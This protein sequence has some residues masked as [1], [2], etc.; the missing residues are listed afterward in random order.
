MNNISIVAPKNQSS[1]GVEK[2]PE[3]KPFPSHEGR[4]QAAASSDV[5]RL[6]QRGSSPVQ[7]ASAQGQSAV[8]ARE[9]SKE[10]SRP[11]TVSTLRVAPSA[12]D[13]ESP[14]SPGKYSAWK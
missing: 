14:R 4:S 2:A 11:K 5:S 8:E 9:S 1:G 3:T 12:M 13:P 7:A 6:P 10:R